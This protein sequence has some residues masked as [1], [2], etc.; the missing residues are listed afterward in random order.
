MELTSFFTRD[1]SLQKEIQPSLSGLGCHVTC[2]P[3][4]K[5][6]GYFHAVPSGRLHLHAVPSGRV[7][8]C[9][10]GAT[11]LVPAFL[12]LSNGRLKE[13]FAYLVAAGNSS[14]VSR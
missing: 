8:L 13:L 3:A 6:A 14:R 5:L 2:L 12:R 1:N 9:P 4:S 7:G 11:R 10:R